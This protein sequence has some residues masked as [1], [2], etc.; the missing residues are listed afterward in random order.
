MTRGIYLVAM[1][2]VAAGCSPY[3]VERPSSV[4]GQICAA[5]CDA[6]QQQCQQ[7]ARLEADSAASRCSSQHKRIDAHCNNYTRDEDR[8]HCQ[9][10]NQASHGCS[11]GAVNS[12]GCHSPWK[13]CVLDCGGRLITR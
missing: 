10:V 6:V 1:L 8:R 3:R 11:V 12:S 4:A 7:H 9:A 13:Q 5:Q 2:I